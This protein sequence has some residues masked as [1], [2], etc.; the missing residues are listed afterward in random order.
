MIETKEII[1]DP[2]ILSELYKEALFSD[3]DRKPLSIVGFYEDRKGKEYKGGYYDYISDKKTQTKI[4]LRLNS[5][6]KAVLNHGSYYQ[7]NGY[8]KRL[9]SKQELSINIFFHVTKVEKEEKEVQLI[10]E[11]EYNIIKERFDKGLFNVE[12]YLL[13]K[14]YKEIKPTILIITGNE[15]IVMND[16]LSQLVDDDL[17]DIHIEKVNLSSK[18]DIFNLV[19]DLDLESIELIAFVRGGGSGLLL[20]EEQDLCKK[21]LDLNIPFVTAIGHEVDKPLLEKISDKSFSTPS[22]FGTFLQYMVRLD[23]ERKYEIHIR[24]RQFS[25]LMANKEIEISKLNESHNFIIAR[26]NKQLN[27]SNVLW[28]SIV[29]VLI[30]FIGLYF[31]I[32][33]KPI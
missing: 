27:R 22:A 20:F 4:T 1:Y 7:L 23:K 3:F 29:L 24:D 18:T 2:Y 21:V 6:L 10:S 12:P 15:S 26:K 5:E 30:L 17:Y 25:E 31:L 9:K 19:E 16:V 8:I 33:N 14:L 32:K 28:A 13:E 11:Q